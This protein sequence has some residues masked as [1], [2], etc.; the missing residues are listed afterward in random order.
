MYFSA[1][2][3]VVLRDTTIQWQ[4]FDY[5]MNEYYSLTSYSDTEVVTT[6]FQ[7]LVLENEWVKLCLIPEFGGRV[8]SFIYKPT[9][10]EQLYQN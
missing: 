1:Y 7:G 8:I 10:K 4:H 9:G 2:S 3:Q 6:S 5:Q